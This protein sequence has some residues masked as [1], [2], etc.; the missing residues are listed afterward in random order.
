MELYILDS[1]LRRTAVI[2]EFE[3]LIWTERYR[4][5]GDFEMKVI[6]TP[7]SRTTLV[8]GTQVTV[9]NTLKLATIETVDDSTDDEG[10]AILT[11]KGPTLENIIQERAG[12]VAWDNLTTTPK[13][14]MTGDPVSVAFALF[15]S[16]C[17]NGLA[18]VNDKIPYIQPSGNLY[19][20][21]T[22]AN[23][24]DYL[25]FVFDF[26][27]LYNQIKTI[28][29]T[30]DLGIRLYRSL[31]T[32]KLYFN[33][34]TGSDRTTRQTTLPPVVFSPALDNLQGVSE[35]NSI[36]NYK[37]VAYVFSAVGTAI[38][39]ADAVDPSI[40]GFDRR[41]IYVNASNVTSTT[42]DIPTALQTAGK[43]ELAKYQTVAALD[44]EIP[45]N[46]QYVFNK[47][48]YLG[49]LVEMR[50]V[51]GVTNIMRVTEQ[52][53]AQDDTGEK[54]YPTLT[55]NLF[56]TPGTWPSYE[57]NVEW[58]NVGEGTWADQPA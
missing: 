3:S 42:A 49:D 38:V 16:V 8:K 9:N 58:A 4:T 41:V 52:I 23:P 6:S 11:V 47:D 19:P 40:S 28:T 44:G 43:T 50:N 7:A 18:N 29:D 21:D 26:D 56:I 13:W 10:R 37:N 31:D 30:W 2:D 14:Q 54:S 39:Y 34:Y 17:I 27:M 33:I 53:R 55:T 1:L 51:D 36:E 20:A 45:Q 46:S 32:T 12:V 25:D 35:L 22:I 57:Y 5:P 15:R 24:T 48:Y